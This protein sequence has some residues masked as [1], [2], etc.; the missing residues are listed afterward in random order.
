MPDRLEA[1][2]ARVKAILEALEIGEEVIARRALPMHLEAA[3]LV[4]AEVGANGRQHLVTPETLAA[5]Q[6]LRASASG[7]GISLSIVSAF[8]TLERQA[9]IV[10][11]KLAAGL[12]PELI[13]RAS[14]PPGYSE[15]HTGRAIDIN[16]PGARPLEE[17]FESTDAFVWLGANAASYGFSLSYPRNNAHGFIYE[18][19]HWCF[20]GGT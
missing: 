19:W 10:R 17:E 14:A 12:S 7:D 16:T 11:G 5:W 20:R 9:D 1:Y 6:Q 13:F 8:R 3:E 2:C 15:H 4:L 18:P